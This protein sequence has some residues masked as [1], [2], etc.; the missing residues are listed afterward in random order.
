M[1]LGSPQASPD[2]QDEGNRRDADEDRLLKQ[3]PNYPEPRQQGSLQSDASLD[4]SSPPKSKEL[5]SRL[6]QGKP[7][8]RV[9]EVQVA[10]WADNVM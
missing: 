8:S 5:G 9:L 7:T 10:M 1:F 6:R 3:E 4:G 2:H